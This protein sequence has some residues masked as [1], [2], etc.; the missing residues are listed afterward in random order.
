MPTKNGRGNC[1][2]CGARCCWYVVVELDTPAA[3]IDREEIRWLLAHENV[4]VYIDG[5]DGTWNVQFNTPCTYLDANNRCT[6]YRRRFD[7]CKDHDPETCEDS[8]GEETDT[9]FH[10]TEDFD[11][12]WRAEKARRR[13]KRKKPRKQRTRNRAKRKK[14]KRGSG[15][16]GKGGSGKATRSKKGRSRKRSK[17]KT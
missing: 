16:K 9:I 12:W 4:S 6:I 11:R 8:D 17:R 5:D 15:K 14:E 2:T 3:K 7:I 10:T 1:A 13:R